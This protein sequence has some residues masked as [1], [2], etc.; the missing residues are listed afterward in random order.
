MKY[1]ELKKMLKGAGCYLHKEGAN[2]E[3]WYSPKTNKI[4]TVGR[5]NSQEVAKGTLDDILKKSGL[6]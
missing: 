1:S 2:H 5:H 3:H 4:F 6:K